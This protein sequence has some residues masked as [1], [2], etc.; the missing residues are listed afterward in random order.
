MRTFNRTSTIQSSRTN[1][2]RNDTSNF[3]ANK[4]E[5][6]PKCYHRHE[7]IEFSLST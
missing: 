2:R 1:R 5:S 6:T 4:F 3:L 7:D